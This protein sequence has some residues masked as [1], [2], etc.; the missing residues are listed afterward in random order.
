MIKLNIRYDKSMRI[1]NLLFY[2]GSIILLISSFFM[3]TFL[4][5]KIFS[6]LLFVF[7]AF[8]FFMDEFLPKKIFVDN[9][10]LY[11]SILNKK[12]SILLDRIISFSKNQETC[13]SFFCKSN[14]NYCL[15]YEGKEIF[16]SIKEEALLDKIFDEKNI[17]KKESEL[18][19]SISK[20]KNKSFS[21]FIFS[22]FPYILICLNSCLI[23]SDG[24]ATSSNYIIHLFYIGLLIL[25]ASFFLKFCFYL[26]FRLKSQRI[27]GRRR[28]I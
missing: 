23:N 18:N 16:I 22:I 21:Y 5:A 4:I 1:I 27:I 13:N 8:A 17:L 9:N 26:R 20:R 28:I 15:F 3:Q 7:I 6:M 25:F 19:L 12:K 14:K 11:L 2:T 24:F 10:Y